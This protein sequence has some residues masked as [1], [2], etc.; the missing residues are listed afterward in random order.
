MKIVIFGF[1]HAGQA[2]SN[3]IKNLN[4][5]NLLTVVDTDPQVSELIPFNAVFF[6][7]VPEQKFDLA[8]ISTPPKSHLDLYQQVANC[9]NRIILEKPFA[10]SPSEIK[11]IFN[12][13]KNGDLFFSIHAGYGKEVD[14]AIAKLK[15]KQSKYP[16]QIT[17]LFC[18]P[19]S[20][21]G[22]QNLGGA[23]DSIFNAL[24]IINK[25]WDDVSLRNIKIK[26]IN[27]SYLNLS[28]SSKLA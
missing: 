28:A 12:I 27:L 20:P 3:A 25:L 4:L 15:N 2:Y 8:I 22:P 11:K 21:N 14:L 7:H 19:Y 13:A 18:D 24:C 10:L 26:L 1:G 5:E 23:W 17:Q 16:Q 6:D 9:T